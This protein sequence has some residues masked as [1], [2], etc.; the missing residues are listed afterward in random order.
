M[1]HLR[2]YKVRP[3]KLPVTGDATL[4]ITGKH[5]DRVVAISLGGVYLREF[6]R[7]NDQS[8]TVTVPPMPEGPHEVALIDER[9]DAVL[10]RFTAVPV[11][12]LTPVVRSIHPRVD[13][14]SRPYPKL[15]ANYYRARRIVYK[16]DNLRG[17]RSV[18]M[19]GTRLK[20]KVIDDH[21][22]EAWQRKQNPRKHLQKHQEIASSDIVA[23]LHQSVV[24]TV[25]QKCR[26][27]NSSNRKQKT[28]PS[29][30]FAGSF[31]RPPPP[32]S[33]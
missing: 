19:D 8:I 29:V 33:Q 9:G 27:Q 15:P 21:T 30:S 14:Y 5:L 11:D 25:F 2:I 23:S 1:T 4:R 3:K 32:R 20:H 16:G 7:L 6:R 18:W 10:D 22:V 31:S 13:Y 12:K 26:F 24:A 17:V 28:I